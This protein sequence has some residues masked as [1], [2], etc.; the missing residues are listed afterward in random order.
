MGCLHV[1]ATRCKLQRKHLTKKELIKP[2]IE[3]PEEDTEKN[4]LDGIEIKDVK[5]ISNILLIG[6]DARNTEEPSRSD[7]M[8]ILSIDKIHGKLKLTSIMRDTYADIPEH[9]IKAKPF[10]LFGDLSFHRDN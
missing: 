4:E 9:V 7:S 3:E 8:M 5:D 2:I 1:Q 6:C 10:L